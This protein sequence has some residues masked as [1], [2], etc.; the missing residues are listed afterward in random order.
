MTAVG[1]M[2]ALAA[3]FPLGLDGHHVHRKQFPVVCQFRL[4]L[5]GLGFSLAY[6]SMFTKIWWVHTVFTK[7]DDKKEKRKVNKKENNWLSL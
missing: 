1:C 5:L 4:W 6:G 2:M 3:V 7:K